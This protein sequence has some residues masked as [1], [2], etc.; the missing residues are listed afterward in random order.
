MS[1]TLEEKRSDYLYSGTLPCAGGV[2]FGGYRF[3]FIFSLAS[4]SVQRRVL[5]LQKR[6]L[7]SVAL[8]S[9]ICA[10][11]FGLSVVLRLLGTPEKSRHI[12]GPHTSLADNAHCALPARL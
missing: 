11:V 6:I 8:F 4:T 9:A 1:P 2:F 12:D 10:S 5:Q 3:L 7:S